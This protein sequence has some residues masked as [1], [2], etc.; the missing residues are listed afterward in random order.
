MDF[1]P[2][3]PCNN[4]FPVYLK[5]FTSSVTVHRMLFHCINYVTD[6]GTRLVISM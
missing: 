4:I 6:Y 5:K 1:I 3:E 2:P